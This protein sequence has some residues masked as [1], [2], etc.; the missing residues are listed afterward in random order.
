MI[1][2]LKTAPALATPAA[3]RFVLGSCSNF[4]TAN[5]WN[6]ATQCLAKAPDFY[7]HL[8]DLI[9]DDNVDAD[10]PYFLA[11]IAAD[12]L[13]LKQNTK[14]YTRGYR[15]WSGVQALNQA[16]PVYAQPDDHDFVFNDYEWD[17]AIT[18]SDYATVAAA[19]RQAWIEGTPHPI[20]L[21]SQGRIMAYQFSW[22]ACRFIV[23]DTRSQRRSSSGTILG[24]SYGHELFNQ[25]A[26][27][28]SAITKA[29]QDGVKILFLCCSCTWQGGN[30]GFSAMGAS[31]ERAALCN[32]IRSTVASYPGM[33]VCILVGDMHLC[34]VDDGGATTDYSTGGISQ[35]IQIVGSPW[36]S[37]SL[38]T[39]TFSWDGS[40]AKHNTS[41]EMLCTID[42]DAD[43]EQI[44]IQID[45]VV[46]GSAV[47]VASYTTEDLTAWA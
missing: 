42:V 14:Y 32:H 27:I 24:A 11:R 12:P 44:S 46:T 1:G 41:D 21:D 29:G 31:A 28:T 43:N 7:I 47:S 5:G 23:L 2:T 34:A 19:S 39:G 8:G 36:L 38:D 3:F 16:V 10:N 9:Y 30:D 17:T 22:A 25:Y 26:A 6:A 35:I 33:R 40:P 4:T 45:N 13:E 37:T 18:G 20:L 15:K